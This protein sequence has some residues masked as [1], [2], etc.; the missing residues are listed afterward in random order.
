MTSDSLP[1]FKPDLRSPKFTRLR[2]G[3]VIATIRT[4]ILMVL[5]ALAIASAWLLSVAYGTYLVSPWTERNGLH[6]LPF[7][8]AVSITVIAARGMYRPGEDRRNYLGLIKAT[9]ISEVLLLLV[10]FLYEPDEYISRSSFLLSWVLTSL[11]ICLGRFVFDLGTELIRQRGMICHPAFLIADAQSRE[12]SLQLIREEKCYNILGVAGASALDRAN[13]E[14]TFE[15]LRNLGIV[16]AFVSWDAIKNRLFLCWHFQSAGITLR[17]LPTDVNSFFPKSEFWII[18]GVPSLTVQ[19]PVLVGGDYWVKRCFDFC[20]ALMAILLLLPVYIAIAVWI[21]L[22]SPGPIFFR[23]TRIGLHGRKFK[24]WKFRTMV[25]NADQLQVMLESQNEMKDGVLFKM[26]A[27]PRV[28]KVGQFLRQYSLDE[29]PQLFNVLLGEMSLVGPRPLPVRDVERFKERHYIRQEVLPGI[30]GL[31]QV[32]GRA[33]IT[34]F[35][36]AVNL[37]ITYIANWSLWMDLKIL[38][39]TVKVVLCKTGAY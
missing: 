36:E 18:G 38:L 3:V 7:I 1:A 8:V 35:E 39:Q 34:D 25:V 11:F 21:K 30:T 37:D 10:A 12:R 6:F 28:T 15:T 13:R 24:V 9:T 22:D 5:D 26:K 16:E 17:I 32:S 14:A 27:D 20:C 23:Q 29:L 31:W 33:D 19:S 2:R 4:L